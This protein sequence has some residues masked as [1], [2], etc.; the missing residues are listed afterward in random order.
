MIRI[1]LVDDDIILLNKMTTL[2]ETYSASC[3]VVERAMSG[4]DAV[5]A[6]DDCEPNLIFMDVELPGMNGI[7]AT[8][9]IKEKY[10]QIS[11]IALSNYDNFFYLREMLKSGATDYILKHELS[12]D[13]IGTQITKVSNEL[14]TKI[15]FFGEKQHE[16]SLWEK[17]DYFRQMLFHEHEI[18]SFE[19]LFRNED[20]NG[21]YGFIVFQITNFIVYYEGK[22]KENL[23]KSI[24]TI[25]YNILPNGSLAIEIE[26]G[27]YAILVP[28]HKNPSTSVLQKNLKEYVILIRS[29]LLKLLNIRIIDY[30]KVIYDTNV[31]LASSY[32]EAERKIGASVIGEDSHR[33]SN[34]L[35]IQCL[36]HVINGEEQVFFDTFEVVFEYGKEQEISLPFVHKNVAEMMKLI[37][38]YL[39]SKREY[40][41]IEEDYSQQVPRLFQSQSV[42]TCENIF[43]EVVGNVFTNMRKQKGNQYSEYIMQALEYIEKNYKTDLSLDVIANHIGI[44]S[45]YLSNLFKK[46]VEINFVTYLAKYRLKKSEKHILNTKM[47]IKEIAKIVGYQNP[48][49]FVSV[50]KQEY[51]CTP[52]EFRN[53]TSY[54][55][56][57]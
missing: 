3:M 39:N 34:M 24:L 48:S 52:M 36:N 8:R 47:P 54:N 43:R 23:L 5:A 15:D 26:H 55:N 13:T 20:K 44:S 27:E 45:V 28:L 21:A 9:K 40:E 49:Y 57:K 37:Q 33:E 53:V 18:I 35:L 42:Q 41:K 16:I 19:K 50:F 38:N 46:E 56:D 17:Q 7:E 31:H 32:Q 6:I 10:P 22:K 2:L 12:M 29:N 11:I 1:L 30:D 4:V 14:R 25:L 51:G